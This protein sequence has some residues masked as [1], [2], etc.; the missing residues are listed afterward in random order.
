MAPKLLRIHGKRQVQEPLPA[1]LELESE[2]LVAK[3]QAYLVT[4][5]H[6]RQ[7]VSTTGIRLVAPG[8][9]LHRD[10][11]GCLLDACS[12]PLY[13]TPRLAAQGV[14]VECE[15]RLGAVGL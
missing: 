2:S 15:T 9:K 11:L 3:R 5:A 7:E 10:V 1:P 14:A 8:T 12:R 6:P 13:T 4:L